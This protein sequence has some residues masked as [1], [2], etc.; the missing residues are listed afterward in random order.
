IR[1]WNDPYD[2]D[3]NGYG[4]GNN[5]LD[6]AIKIGQRATQYGMQAQINFH[7][8]DFCADPGKQMSPKEWMDFSIEEKEAALYDYTKDSLE[9]LVNAGVNVGM[10]QIGNETNNQ[11][12]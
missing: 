8:S 6:K 3:G 1:V 11:F 12:V 9:E 10:V 4:G 5:D 7:Y 2:A